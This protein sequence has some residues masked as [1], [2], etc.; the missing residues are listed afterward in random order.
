MFHTPNPLH[1]ARDGPVMGAGDAPGTYTA[2][3]PLGTDRDA[4]VDRTLSNHPRPAQVISALFN[5]SIT[6]AYVHQH[7]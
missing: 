7:D 4:D 6:P 1:H 3:L 5:F 2:E